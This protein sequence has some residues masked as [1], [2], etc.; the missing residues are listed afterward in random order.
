[1]LGRKP[2]LGS[3][4]AAS[5]MVS[6]DD[7]C[8]C[9]CQMFQKLSLCLTGCADGQEGLLLNI[10]SL[11]S[12]HRYLCTS[13]MRAWFTKTQRAERQS[14]CGSPGPSAR[15]V[16]LQTRAAGGRKSLTNSQEIGIYLAPPGA[17]LGAIR[18]ARC[19]KFFRPEEK[20]HVIF[21]LKPCSVF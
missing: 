8:V 4:G 18:V 16:T 13:C 5:F 14:C 9:V 7:I 10:L 1:M 20:S 12:R 17:L 19:F 3:D 11:L 6:H 21:L 2:C 15:C